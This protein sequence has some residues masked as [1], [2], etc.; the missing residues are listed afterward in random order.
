MSKTKKKRIV[1]TGLGVVSSIGIGKNDF[2]NNLING[3]SGV[4]TIT[5]FDVSTFPTKI[6]AEV[7]DFDPSLFM[8]KKEARRFL[9]I[10][11]KNVE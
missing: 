3:K 2:W 1:V 10:V 11:I 8:E 7:K 9:N 5:R 6:A 4:A